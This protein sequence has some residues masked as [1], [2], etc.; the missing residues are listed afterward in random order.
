MSY[1]EPCQPCNCFSQSL[2]K[3]LKMRLEFVPEISLHWSNHE[4]HVQVSVAARLL[5]GN[6]RVSLH[7]FTQWKLFFFGIEPCRPYVCLPSIS[8]SKYL[9]LSV[10]QFRRAC[11]NSLYTLIATGWGAVPCSHHRPGKAPRSLLLIWFSPTVLP[12]HLSV[13]GLSLSHS[14]LS[15]WAIMR[16]EIM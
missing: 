10:A 1:V 5:F 14:L 13:S 4:K 15:S 8:L 7:S 3:I 6:L 16:H 11:N 12:L 9:G 2:I